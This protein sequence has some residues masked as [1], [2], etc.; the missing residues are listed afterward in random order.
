MNYVFRDDLNVLLHEAFI[1]GMRNEYQEAYSGIG[2]E[3][4]LRGYE[5][6]AGKPADARVIAAFTIVLQ[7]MHDAWQRGR[8]ANKRNKN[9][10]C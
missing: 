10:G 5:H 4:A 7:A 6:R 3:Q 8:A 9:Q 1:D 2:L